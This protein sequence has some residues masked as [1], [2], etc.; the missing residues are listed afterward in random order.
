MPRPTS[1]RYRTRR[2]TTWISALALATASIA[3]CA[4]PGARGS[5]S[6]T[7]GAGSSPERSI[8]AAWREMRTL[9][10]EPP[11][12]LTDLELNKTGPFS[13]AEVVKLADIAAGVIKRSASPEL[14]KMTPDDAFASVYAR[15][16]AATT[17]DARQNNQRL[18][19]GHDWQW[20]AASRYTTTPTRPKV[21]KVAAEATTARGSLDNGNPAP[22]LNVTVQ[23][24][25]L[26][27]VQV[28][29]HTRP[30]VVRRTVRVAT[31][32]PNGGPDFWPAV[33]ARASPFGNDSC[34][35][36]DGAQL[37]PLTDP[38]RLRADIRDLEQ[39]LSNRTVVAE[40]FDNTTEADDLDAQL[41]ETCPSDR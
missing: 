22:Y 5:S 34:A 15:Q 2:A 19:P 36:F 39:S 33:W 26:Q 4:A 11:V 30:I 37:V 31:F 24:H 38:E 12:A 8:E 1:P 40:P 7:V 6:E 35:L 13:R 20:L 41:S 17:F 23:A 27:T 3:G 14:S 21:L 28:D 16:L 10:N 9:T 32:K 29:G 25:L 18:I